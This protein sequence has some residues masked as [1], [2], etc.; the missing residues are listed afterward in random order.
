MKA[1][2]IKAGNI[3]RFNGALVSVEELL[4]QNLGN[5]RAFYQARMRKVKTNKSGGYRFRTD[6]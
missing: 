4:H 2:E 3:L 1:S 5:I 6:E